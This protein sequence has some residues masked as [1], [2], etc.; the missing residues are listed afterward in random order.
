[1]KKIKPFMKSTVIVFV[2]L[3]CMFAYFPA[4]VSHAK[5]NKEIDKE[6]DAALQQFTGQVKRGSEFLKA[7]KGVLVVP[8]I[9]KGGL[10]VGGEYGAGALRIDGKT[11]DYY[12]LS[13][14]TIG[15]EAGI[16]KVN[17]ILIFLK[18]EA[19]KKFRASSGWKSGI[20]E[21]V[22]FIHKGEEESLD[23]N[24][25]KHSVIGFLFHQKGL[26]LDFTIEGAKFTKRK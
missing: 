17:L 10:G 26:M 8:N 6:A 15:F 18:D 14:G 13:G 24:T 16:E 3:L 22:V 23:T 19:L 12:I 25:I 2:V 9:K 4:S 20:D 7:A 5:T 1:M 11:V 21:T